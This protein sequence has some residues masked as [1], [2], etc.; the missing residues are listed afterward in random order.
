MGTKAWWHRLDSDQRHGG[1]EPPA[2][3]LSYGATRG[4][5]RKKRGEAQVARKLLWHAREALLAE[6]FA[7]REGPSDREASHDLE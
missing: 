3:P 5:Y 4:Y 7:A 6:V 2:L 1:Y